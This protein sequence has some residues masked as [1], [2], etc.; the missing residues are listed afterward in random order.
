MNNKLITKEGFKFKFN[1]NACEECGG[2][3]CIGESGYVWVNKEEIE[4]IAKFLGLE[5]EEF[6][7]NY[8][9]K[10][11]YKY[12]LKEIKKDNSYECVFFENGKCLIYEVRP[13]QCREFP[14]WDYFKD[15]F[16]YLLKECPGVVIE[17]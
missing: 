16:S 14:F 10:V 9:R 5:I 4:K 1:P 3:C 13:R 2:K 6:I 11:E 8:L 15:D 12:S 17:S 7:K